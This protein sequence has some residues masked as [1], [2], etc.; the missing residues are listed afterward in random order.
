M[1]IERLHWGA[2]S[3]HLIALWP[4]PVHHEACFASA[5]FTDFG[6]TDDAELDAL[7]G[8]LLLALEKLGPAWTPRPLERRRSLL[9]APTVMP[10]LQ[11]LLASIHWDNLPPLTVHFGD[12]PLATVNTADG[13]ALFWL[14][15]PVGYLPGLLTEVAAGLPVSELELKWTQLMPYTLVV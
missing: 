6:E 8:R 7:T 11:Q 5:G 1:S 15:L 10:L 4:A 14:T 13:H 9:R 3:P 2:A 12:P